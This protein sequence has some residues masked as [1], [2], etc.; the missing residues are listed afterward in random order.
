[1]S[2][3]EAGILDDARVRPVRGRTTLRDVARLADVHTSTVSRALSEK[4]RSM[5]NPET[6][7]RVLAAAEQLDYRPNAMARGLKT[8]RSHSI[9]VLVPDLLNPV[10]PPIVKGIEAALGDAG[11][12]VLLGNA[13]HSREHE[14]ALVEAF[15]GQQVEGMIAFTASDDNKVFDLLVGTGVPV[16]LVNRTVPDGSISAAVPDDAVCSTL[17]VDHLVG[18]GHQRIAHV[19]GPQDT[20]TGQRRRQGFEGAVAKAGLERDPT[21]VVAASRYTEEEG[22]RCCRQLLASGERFTAIVAANDLLA[23]GCYDALAEAG[24]SCPDDI[25]V[26]GCNDMP[27]SD[28][29]DPPL[30]TV[31]IEHHHLGTAAAELLLEQIQTP[32]LPPRQIVTTPTLV[33]RA[34]T[35]RPSTRRRGLGRSLLGRT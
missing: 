12:V 18:L 35:A 9:G 26:V 20:S 4:T 11:Y 14:E 32:G 2:E 21:L 31:N 34:S 7:E 17:A 3:T 28:R 30:T 6:V 15:H 10:V 5:V 33:V 16:V 19:A 27:F 25:S 13:D 22:A 29:F 1:M 24:L 23:L 8:N